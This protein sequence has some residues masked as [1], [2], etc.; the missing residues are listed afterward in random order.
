MD[1]ATPKGNETRFR[2]AH[3]EIR[4]QVVVSCGPTRNHLDHGVGPHV[5]RGIEYENSEL[6]ISDII[7]V[8]SLIRMLYSV[9]QK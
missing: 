4:T 5:L 8:R 7:F 9:N 6:Y 3:A 1:R 2:Y